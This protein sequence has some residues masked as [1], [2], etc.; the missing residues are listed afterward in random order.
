MYELEATDRRER[1]RFFSSHPELKIRQSPAVMSS[2]NRV[3]LLAWSEHCVECAV[4]HCYSTCDLYRPRADLKCRRFTFGIA[5]NDDLRTWLPY[6]VEVDFR[7]I[8][9]IWTK[10]NVRTVPLA[11]YRMLDAAHR[12]LGVVA[13]AG[14]ALLAA[15]VPKRT[16]TRGFYHYRKQLVRALQRGGGRKADGFLLQV[17]N[18]HQETLTLRMVVAPETRGPQSFS[19]HERFDLPPG[20]TERW[21]PVSRIAERV[22]LDQPFEMSLLLGN[23]EPRLLYFLAAEFVSGIS[24]PITQGVA[25]ARS[26]SPSKA[27]TKKVKCIVWDLDNTL[28][29]GVLVESGGTAPKLRPGVL[30]VVR[31]LD[32][33]GILQSVASKNNH[34]EAWSLLE[35]YGLAEY[36]L[37]PQISWGPKSAGLR[38]IAQQLNIG[39]DTLALVDDQPFERGEVAAN[40]SPALALADTVIPTLLQ[41]P[42]FAGSSSAEARQRRVFY[43]TEMKRNEVF[44]GFTGDYIDF[45]RDSRIV[46]DIHPPV[47]EELDRLHELIQRTNQMN[48]SGTRYSRPQ[49][50]EVLDKPELDGFTLQVVDRFGDYGIVGFAVLS[51][52]GP[53]VRM[54]DLAMSCRIQAKHVEHAMLLALMERY[55]R[56]GY[57]SF[58]AEYRR[59]ERNEPASQVFADLA[60]ERQENEGDLEVYRKVLAEEFIPLDYLEVRIG[61]DEVIG[62]P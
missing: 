53:A 10:G 25:E 58:E 4:P 54:V 60:F 44:S 41:D 13:K 36:M 20:F 31:A 50:A 24:G 9:H 18:P 7:V 48:F 57:S 28:W 6:A 5:R 26:A 59:T 8:S 42:R 56:K 11:T 3:S 2:A 14:S 27:E 34:D 22:D 38:A 49:L 23:V 51:R 46:L 40:A 61:Q 37:F 30:D 1:E 21:V 12:I 47:K 35:A 55:R 45:L 52:R 16:L 33:R 17:I 32:E 43:Q 15:I 62:Q 19:F 39:L 29:D